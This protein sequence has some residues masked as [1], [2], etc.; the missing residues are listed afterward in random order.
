[1]DRLAGFVVRHRTSV[2]LAIVLA[3]ALSADRIVDVRALPAALSGERPLAQALRLRFDP[4]T[5][6]LF[7]SGDPARLFY[8]HVRRVF[9]SDEVLVVALVDEASIFTRENLE[10]VQRLTARLAEI[11]GVHHVTSLANALNIRSVGRELE[12]EPFLATLPED[13]AG[14]ERLRREAL[15]NPVYAGNL[16]ARSGRATALLVYLEDMSDADFQARGIDRRVQ[17]VAERERGS[18]R[19]WVTGTAL[20]KA[21]MTR[22]GVHDLVFTT[23]LIGFVM[24]LLSA[25][26]FRSLR[27]TLIPLATIGIG[28]LWSLGVIAASGQPLNLITMML[29]PLVMTIGFSYGNYAV[30]AYYQAARE[31][32]PGQGPAEVVR[33]MLAEQAVPLLLC[34]V[35]TVVG[36]LALVANP[37]DAVREF[38]VFGVAAVSL[39]VVAALLFPPAVLASLPL[40]A[41]PAAAGRDRVGEALGRLAAFDVRRRRAILAVGAAVAAVS[42]FGATR[43]RVNMSQVEN[44]APDHPVRRHFEAINRELEGSNPFYVAIETDRAQGFKEPVNLREIEGLEAWLVAQPEVGGTTSLADYV[45]LINR[46]FHGDDPAYLRIPDSTRMVGQLLYFGGNDELEG[47]VDSRYQTTLVVVRSNVMDTGHVDALVSR[48][49]S[50]LRELPPHL[51]AQVTGNSVVVART[52][53]AL[54]RGQMGSIVLGLVLIFGL[55]AATFISLRVGLIA[56]VPNALPVLVYYGA[57]GWT[58][59]TLNPT[60]SLVACI[61]LGIAVDDTIHLVSGYMA[62]ARRHADQARGA[63]E[64]LTAL[65]RPVTFSSV[66]LCLGFGTLALSEMRNQ[67]EFGALA[68]FTLAVAWLCDVTMTVA[69]FSHVRIVTLWDILSLDLGPEPGRTIPF[70]R[71]LR[72]SQARIV[73][74]LMDVRR[75]PAG[76]RLFAAGQ[77]GDD[78]YVVLDGELRVSMPSEHGVEELARL[79]RGD[80]VGEVALFQGVRSADVEALS[81]VRL[82]RFSRSDLERL[83]RRYPRIGTRVLSNLSEILAGR[84]AEANRAR[85]AA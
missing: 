85:I 75:H 77:P 42:V 62:A 69:L 24:A 59:V 46:G 71:G 81:D 29:P 2:L 50:R 10:T 35:T 21:E 54:S 13:A 32:R 5:S 9:G 76:H 66:A 84:L 27:G 25:L 37:L 65:A 48:I 1:M 33:A 63:V 80:A 23:P 36:F 47:L 78:M 67:V 73:V 74:L 18:A 51:R 52:L 12:I 39:T 79:G 41:G 60:T 82:L 3:T 83:S 57:L 53:D 64:V 43:I 58:G 56:L 4:S 26:A 22:M 72:T 11:E 17:D 31:A 16:V 7:P 20:V 19:V 14:L 49:E 44:F 40:R 70:F 28:T 68:A 38:G 55:L 6:R 61:V 15:D 45:K 30:A 8:E 34:G